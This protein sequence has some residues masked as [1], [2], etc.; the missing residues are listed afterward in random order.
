MVP[1]RQRF[2]ISDMEAVLAIMVIL[3]ILGTINI[4][5]AS[6]IV[7]ETQYHNPYFFLMRQLLSLGIGILALIFSIRLDYHHWRKLIPFVMVFTIGALLAVL[8]VGVEVNGSKRWLGLGFMQFQPSEMA[9]LVSIVMAAA[10]LG[11]RIDRNQKITLKNI[12]TVIFVVMAV[13]VELQPDMGTMLLVLGIPMLM[14]ILAGMETK[15][16]SMLACAGAVMVILLSFL[17]PYRLERIKTW[18]DPWQYQ[19]DQGYQTVQSMS[20]IGSGGFLGMGLGKGVSKYYYLPEAHTDF[21]FAIYCQ[22]N[23]YVGAFF[24]FFLLVALAIYSGKIANRAVDGFGRMLASG[25][26]ILIVGQAVANISM[27]VGLIPVVGVPL[28]FISYG[29]TSLILNMVGIGLLVNVGSY[30][31]KHPVEPK[32]PVIEEMPRHRLRLVKK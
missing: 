26:L 25:V 19:Q 5:S 13:L 31:A 3:I 9:K 21:A 22:E 2:W 18:Y 29:G 4:F 15:W 7:A 8:L 32:A 12:P 16:V 30:A 24:M 20:A 27:V 17:Q 23:G 10:Y 1:L 28:P 6:F 14:Y 11:P